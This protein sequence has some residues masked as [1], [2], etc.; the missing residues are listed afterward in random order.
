[1]NHWLIVPVICRRWWPRSSSAA[2][3]DLLL[4]RVF[5]IAA[6]ILLLA[7][8][9][10]LY[11]QAADGVPR[12]YALGNWPAPFGIILVL[13]R[14]SAL[15]LLLTAVLAVVVAIYAANGLGQRGGTFMRCSSSS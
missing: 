2:R 6:T 4:Q 3:F 15:M 5:G 13:D 9:I 10:G 11:L 8:A 1:M 14:L 7:V 12:P